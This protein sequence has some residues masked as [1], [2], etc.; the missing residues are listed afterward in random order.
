MDDWR[1]LVIPKQIWHTCIALGTA[2]ALYNQTMRLE[3]KRTMAYC[4]A[5]IHKYLREKQP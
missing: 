3:I 4:Y 1:K 2:Q 5:E